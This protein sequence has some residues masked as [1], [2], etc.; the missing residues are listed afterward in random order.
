MPAITAAT[1]PG[2]R[3]KHPSI[4]ASRSVLG[5]MGKIEGAGTKYPIEG[6]YAY[7]T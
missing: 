3:P 2:V 6:H 7:V 1:Q 4:T 5:V